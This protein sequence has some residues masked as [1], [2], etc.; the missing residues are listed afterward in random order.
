RSAPDGVGTSLVAVAAP[1]R[2]AVGANLSRLGRE[3]PTQALQGPPATHPECVLAAMRRAMET[4]PAHA[5]IAR[6]AEHQYGVFTRHQ[7]LAA[8]VSSAQLTS[9]CR[10]GVWER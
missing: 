2:P 10:S 7:A 6:A 5:A 4:G 8:G 9:R 1:F 3:N